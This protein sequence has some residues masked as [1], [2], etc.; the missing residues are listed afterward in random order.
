MALFSHVIE[1]DAN[2]IK[3]YVMSE[4]NQEDVSVVGRGNVVYIRF[5]NMNQIR[6][7]FVW[8]DEENNINVNIAVKRKHTSLAPDW[9]LGGEYSFEMFDY[10]MACAK[11][12]L[13]ELNKRGN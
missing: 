12:K 3:D 4:F 7:E 9:M 8:D 10:W 11:Q 13:K 1:V 6:I 2:A 5:N